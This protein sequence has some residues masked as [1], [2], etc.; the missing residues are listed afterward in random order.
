MGK[1]FSRLKMAVNWLYC[2]GRGGTAETFIMG[3][4]GLLK[5]G[6]LNT[7]NLFIGEAC[8][9]FNWRELNLS[10]LE[11]PILSLLEEFDLINHPLNL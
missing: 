1:A 5:A 4:A 11:E 2:R 10:L 8:L 3:R 6:W 7:F 9:I